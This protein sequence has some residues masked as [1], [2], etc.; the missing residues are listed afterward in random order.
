MERI[1]EGI[2]S[3]K[4]VDPE[5]LS[6]MVEQQVKKMTGRK[7]KEADVHMVD[8]ALESPRGITSAYAT[9]ATR[10]YQQ[11]AQ[12]TQAHNRGFN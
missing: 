12:S 9:Q 11:Q 1:D 10:P 7:T 3:K 8:N 5:S 4:I 2:T 6:F